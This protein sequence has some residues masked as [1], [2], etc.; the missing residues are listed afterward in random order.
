MTPNYNQLPTFAIPSQTTPILNKYKQNNNS[1]LA[2]E[3]GSAHLEEPRTA[4]LKPD[5]LL[6]SS[7]LTA[8]SKNA[9]C[10]KIIPSQNLRESGRSSFGS[11]N[12]FLKKRMSRQN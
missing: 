2:G 10:E 11:M 7:N 6:R 1:L 9:Y 8:T 5:R 4:Q 3:S 12:S